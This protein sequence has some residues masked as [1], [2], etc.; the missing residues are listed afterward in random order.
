MNVERVACA[1]GGACIAFAACGACAA[2]TAIPPAIMA[3]C[4][5]SLIAVCRP[6]RC[7]ASAAAGACVAVLLPAVPQ[8]AAGIVV[9]RSPHATVRDDL[10]DTLDRLDA[11]PAGVMGANVTVSGVWTPA[12]DGFDATV[13]RRIM[14][15]CAAD[16]VDVGFDVEPVHVA[17]VAPQSFVRVTGFVGER[18]RDGE[19]R[20]VLLGALVERAAS[21]AR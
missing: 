19:A 13:S 16:A 20:Y 2:L 18:M 14:N 15:C 12:H 10:L 21:D 4:G 8:K 17:G 7:A 3:L 9:T 6:R 1:I 5:A 11:D